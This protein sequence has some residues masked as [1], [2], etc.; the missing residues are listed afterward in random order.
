MFREFHGEDLAS[1]AVRRPWR[2]LERRVVRRGLIGRTLIAIEPLICAVVFAAL[3]VALL[4]HWPQP[5]ELTPF[6][7]PIFALAGVFCL[8]WAA[9]LLFAP[10]RAY[11]HTYGP[12][13]VVDGYLRSRRADTAADD[14]HDHAGYFAVLDE[15]RRVVAE[16]PV[17]GEAMLPDSIR[18][19]FVEFSRYGGIHSV[20]GRGTGIVPASL[21]PLGIGAPL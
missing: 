19:A 14:E 21:R 16:W 3:T 12:I 13:Y 6:L 15:R 4:A 20:N 8:V 2:P 1:I 10:L 17:C 7:A 5:Q 11:A 9:G 18:P